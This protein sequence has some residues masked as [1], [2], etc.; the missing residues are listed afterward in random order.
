MST[1]ITLSP[2]EQALV[3]EVTMWLEHA[4]AEAKASAQN[5][6]APILQQHGLLGKDC[7]FQRVENSWVLIPPAEEQDATQE[8]DV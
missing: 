7:K 4:V 1:P 8:G 2:V 3:I 6:L 5:R